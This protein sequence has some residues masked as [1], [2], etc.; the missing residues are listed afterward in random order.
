MTALA[1]V[2]KWGSKDTWLRALFVRSCLIWLFRDELTELQLGRLTWLS[3]LLE[4]AYTLANGEAARFDTAEEAFHQAVDDVK[5]DIASRINSAGGCDLELE[6]LEKTVCGAQAADPLELMFACL[7]RNTRRIYKANQC[8][9]MDLKRE[10]LIDHPRGESR[11]GQ[12]SDPYHVN[13]ETYVRS[14]TA[15]VELQ[16][17]LDRFDVLSLLAVPALLTHELVSHTQA[18]EDR[19]DDESYW[20][21][22]VMDWV[23]SFFFDKWATWIDL[24]AGLTKDHG[25]QLR[26]DRMSNSRYTGRLAAENFVQW[27]TRDRLVRYK[28]VAERKTAMFALQVNVIDRPLPEKDT[29]ASRMANIKRDTAL[30]E[31][32]TGWLRHRVGAADLLG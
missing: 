9:R 10:W 29:L 12:Y 23:S 2:E 11:P 17:F 5:R 15:T 26:N 13:A 6:R 30:Q 8:R 25:E 18:R 14:D 31:G 16:V 21:E 20:A 24:P 7:A 3:L 4:N 27:L 32:I 22:G 28:P 1:L 19:N